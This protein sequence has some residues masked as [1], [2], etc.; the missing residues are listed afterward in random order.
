MNHEKFIYYK[1]QGIMKDYVSFQWY[2]I[3][4]KTR[5]GVHF[6]GTKTPSLPISFSNQHG[7]MAGGIECHKKSPNFEG[8][9]P[10]PGYCLVTQGECYCDGSSLQAEERLGWVNPDGSDD[11]AIWSVL[12]EYFGYWI[13]NK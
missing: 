3:D 12:H 11:V 9:T 13:E 8:H 5:E 1:S 10:A 2:L 4:K 7:F 6:H